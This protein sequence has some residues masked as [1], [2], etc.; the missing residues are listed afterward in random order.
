[1]D[2]DKVCQNLAFNWFILELLSL[3]LDVINAVHYESHHHPLRHGL[4]T[5]LQPRP[6]DLQSLAIYRILTR[7]K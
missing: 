5:E 4:T 3:G 7:L 2:S 6:V 1:M